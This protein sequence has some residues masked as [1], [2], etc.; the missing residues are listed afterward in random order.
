M[1][2]SYFHKVKSLCVN[3]LTEIGPKVAQYSGG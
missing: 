3:F 1:L 2:E